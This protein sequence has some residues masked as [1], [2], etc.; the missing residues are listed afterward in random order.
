MRYTRS[1][2]STF[3][4]ILNGAGICALVVLVLGLIAV[5]LGL[6]ANFR[7]VFNGD[8]IVVS[9]LAAVAAFA[10][11]TFLLVFFLIL[12]IGLPMWFIGSSAFS[13][14]WAVAVAIGPLAIVGAAGAMARLAGMSVGL[15]ILSVLVAFSILA[16]VVTW[17]SAYEVRKSSHEVF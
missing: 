6:N 12:L 8:L 3:R 15:T 4:S 2:T 16:G 13:T 7:F 5:P 11:L 14:H 1:S 10:T 9:G 17:R